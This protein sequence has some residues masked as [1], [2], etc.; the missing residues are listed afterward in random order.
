MACPDMPHS[1]QP[2][3]QIPRDHLENLLKEAGRHQTVEEFLNKSEIQSTVRTVGLYQ[4][5]AKAAAWS[6]MWLLASALISAASFLFSPNK[7]DLVASILLG[8]MT[9]LEFKVHTWFLHADPRGALWGYRNQ[10]LFALLFLIYGLY[11]FLIPTPHK[12]LAELG[13]QNLDEAVENLEK[14][15]YAAIGIGGSTGQYMLALYYRK[16]AKLSA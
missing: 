8:G 16:A 10:C 3:I 5:R 14:I 2:L 15:V 9:V 7:E 1:K 4:K 13:M 6:R 12:E 11:H